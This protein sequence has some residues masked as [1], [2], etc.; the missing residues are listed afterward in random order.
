MF[1][2]FTY[3]VISPLTRWLL[4]ESGSEVTRQSTWWETIHRFVNSNVICLFVSLF[5]SECPLFIFSAS[6]TCVGWHVGSKDVRWMWIKLH[7]L[8]WIKKYTVFLSYLKRIMFSGRRKRWQSTWQAMLKSSEAWAPRHR[9]FLIHFMFEYFKSVWLLSWLP[10]VRAT[11]SCWRSLS[12][13]GLSI[14]WVALSFCYCRIKKGSPNHLLLNKVPCLSQEKG[15][16][17]NLFCPV[18]SVLVVWVL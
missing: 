18:L 2:T 17:W 4:S 14:P 9:F 15:V 6:G 8:I 12:G 7:Y 11:S 1:G 13:H 16:L 10:G 5:P 3:W